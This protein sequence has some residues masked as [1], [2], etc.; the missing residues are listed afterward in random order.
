MELGNLFFGHSCGAVKVPRTASYEG[1][2]YALIESMPEE[3][4]GYGYAFE[5]EVFKMRP[6]YWGDCTCGFDEKDAKWSEENKHLKTC[7]QAEY[8]RIPGNGALGKKDAD[9][10]A[11]CERRGIPWDNGR[12][13]AVHCDCGYQKRWEEFAANNDH[14]SSCPIVEPNFLYKPT[15]YE[16]RWYKYPLRDS[17][18]SH[19]LS[20]AQ[21]MAMMNKCV[22]SLGQ[23]CPEGK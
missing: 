21:F 3:S 15:G 17:Y 10:K 12:G 20:A 5:N 8:N 22:E 16:L 2:I 18:A 11:L 14:T 4:S 13:C 1:P 23:K 19:K 7:Y 9:I 6:Y